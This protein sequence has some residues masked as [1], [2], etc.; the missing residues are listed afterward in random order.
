MWLLFYSISSKVVNSFSK[1]ERISKNKRFLFNLF[2]PL[3]SLET[4]KH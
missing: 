1:T 3:F 2:V 4:L